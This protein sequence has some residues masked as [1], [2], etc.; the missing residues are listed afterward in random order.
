MFVLKVLTAVLVI[1]V[2]YYFWLVFNFVYKNTLGYIMAIVDARKAVSLI[3]IDKSLNQAIKWVDK[4]KSNNFPTKYFLK[5]P[6]D[7]PL[8]CSNNSANYSQCVI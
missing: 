4:K 6:N 5:K 8:S 2:F 1:W 3:F 7:V